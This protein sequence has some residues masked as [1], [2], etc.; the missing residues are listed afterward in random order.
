MDSF[1]ND[2]YERDYSF[3]DLSLRRRLGAN[4]LASVQIRNALNSHTY[5]YTFG[6]GADHLREY[7][8]N[9]P[10]VTLAVSRSF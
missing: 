9:G 2:P 3:V 5:W 6:S 10:T 8:R 7:I 1:G 4:G